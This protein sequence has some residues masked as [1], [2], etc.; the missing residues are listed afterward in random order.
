MSLRGLPWTERGPAIAEFAIDLVYPKR[1]AG[2]GARGSWLCARCDAEPLR[3]AP[4]WCP[5][6]GVPAPQ[7]SCACDTMPENLDRV[8]SVGPYSGWLRRAIIDFKYH[9]EWARAK[10]LGEWLA[11]VA[12]D[13]PGDTLVPVPLHPSRLRQR[14]FNQSLLLAERAAVPMS[15]PVLD[16]LARLRRTQAQAQLPAA[17][18]AANVRGAFALKPGTHIEGKSVILVD[19]VMTTGAT[20]TSCASALLEGGAS[21]VM[22]ATLAR[23]LQ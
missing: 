21:A 20:L 7:F 19:D 3:F 17:Q 5:R 10:P 23:E 11:G 1:C 18:R 13:L 12:A 16:A 14:G 6:C 15:A 8:R 9:G 4:P 2:C 22:V